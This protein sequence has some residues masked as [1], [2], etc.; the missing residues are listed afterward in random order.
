MENSKVFQYLSAVFAT[1]LI[2]S[3]T[4]VNGQITTPCTNPMIT[5][6][7]PCLNYLTGST[8]TGGSPTGDCCGALRS[9]TKLLV[10]KVF[11]Y[12]AKP[13]VSLY[14]LQALFFLEPQKQQPQHPQAHPNVY[15]LDITCC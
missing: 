12:N 10:S 11:Q 1:T 8:G 7:T 5:S 3:I 6:F 14:Q 13:L 2:L 4:F 15:I 9:L